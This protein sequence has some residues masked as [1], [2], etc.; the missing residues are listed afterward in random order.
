MNAGVFLRTFVTLM[1][2]EVFKHCLVWTDMARILAISSQV[3]RGHVGLSAIVPALQRLGHEVLAMPT[4]LLSNHPGHKRASGTRI[5]VNTLM[6]MLDVLDANNWLMDIEAVVTGYL[7]TPE[8]V[9]FAGQAID[10]VRSRSPAPLVLVDPVIGDDPGGLYIDPAAAQSMRDKLLPRADILTPNRFELAWLS[11]RVV[12]SIGDAVAAARA[13]LRP[14][15]LATSIPDGD[16]QLANVRISGTSVDVCR[17]TR[18]TRVP[19]G[20]GD[21]LS[22][23]FISQ[24]LINRDTAGPAHALGAAVAGVQA[25]IAGSTGHDDLCLAVADPHTDWARQP[26][27]VV[28]VVSR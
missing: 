14:Q 27:A 5:E 12:N 28:D 18:Q 7:P 4:I 26:A 19:H 20:T 17:V 9:Y 11:G 3:V 15:V 21:L 13:L 2:S 10:L 24:C 1:T 8:H 16:S 6:A 25:A 22:A 23:L